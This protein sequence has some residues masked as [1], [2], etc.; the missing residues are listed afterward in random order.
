MKAVISMDQGD[1]ITIHTNDDE[2]IKGIFANY[3]LENEAMV[4][5]CADDL[6]AFKFN[7]IRLVELLKPIA[8]ANMINSE[9]A[10]S[11]QAIDAWW[12][13][14]RTKSGRTGVTLD[15]GDGVLIAS[16]SDPIPAAK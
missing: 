11:P 6:F 5:Q 2:E 7:N 4:L 16:T 12:D 15:I 8:F 3:D 9:L 14:N 1:E 10:I 13:S